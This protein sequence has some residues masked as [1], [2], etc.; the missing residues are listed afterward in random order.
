MGYYQDGNIFCCVY[1]TGEASNEVRFREVSQGLHI[2]TIIA[3][4]FDGLVDKCDVHF[5]GKKILPDRHKCCDCPLHFY[6]A[7]DLEI[8]CRGAYNPTQ[9]VVHLACDSTRPLVTTA[10]NLDGQQTIQCEHTVSEYLLANCP[11][12]LEM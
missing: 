8:A 4:D 12:S 10:C 2:F 7:E 1:Y 11:L 9:D 3:E 5:K 6:W